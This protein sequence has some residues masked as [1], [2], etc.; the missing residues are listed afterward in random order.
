[1]TSTTGPP[2]A[3]L[4]LVALAATLLPAGARAQS[5][6]PNCKSVIPEPTDAKKCGLDCCMLACIEAEILKA[7]YQRGFYDHI[8]SRK[9]MTKAE[10]EEEERRMSSAAENIRIASLGSLTP[11]NYL[12]LPDVKNICYPEYQ[13]LRR[14]GFL[15]RSNDQGQRI[16]LDYTVKTDLKTCTANSEAMRLI[17]LVTPCQEIGMATQ[18]HEQKHVDDCLKRREDGLP[19]E[20]AP[21]EIA[22]GEVP[23]YDVEIAAL[24]KQRLDTAVVCKIKSCGKKDSNLRKSFDE[25]AQMLGL[26]IDTVIKLGPPKAPSKSPLRRGKKAK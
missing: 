24:E 7:K 22:A 14:A 15:G 9:K 6:D 8:K 3:V 2:R 4:L 16:G 1:M 13:D 21:W 12:A 17:P 23:G 18:A 11:C 10:Y 5:T 19:T 26:L 20:G 25:S